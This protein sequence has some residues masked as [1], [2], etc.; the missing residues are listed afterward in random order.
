MR[1]ISLEINSFGPYAGHQVIDFRELKG[2]NLFL[3]CGP[4]GSGKTTVLDAMC[5]ALYGNTSGNDRTGATMRSEY[6]TPEQKT[7]VIFDFS[8]GSHLYRIERS[9][10]QEIAKKRGSGTKIETASAAFYEIDEEGNVL[11]PIAT[12]NVNG[13]VEKRLGFKSEQFRQVVLLPQGDF[14][15][16]LLAGSAERQEIM[17]VLFHTQRYGRFQELAKARY[18]AIEQRHAA[19]EERIVQVLQLAGAETEEGLDQRQAD[20]AKQLDQ[21]RA[22]GQRAKAERDA[23]QK[24]AAAAEVLAGHWQALKKG[25]QELLALQEQ[26][27][28]M[29]ERS[30][31]IERLKKAQ[32]LSEPCKYLDE[33]QDKGTAAGTALAEAQKKQEA[34][35]QDLVQARQR[36]ADV[37]SRQVTYKGE[38]EQLSRLKGLVEKVKAY[39][40][41][42][43]QFNTQQ[44]ACHK[45]AAAL[46]GVTARL[47]SAKEKI[48]AAQA[49]SEGLQQRRVAQEQLKNQQRLLHERVQQEERIAEL[50]KAI[51]AAHKD[52]AG[53]QAIYDE[54]AR[55]AHEAQV[56]YESVQALFLQGQAGLLAQTLQEGQVCPV[57]GSRQHPQLAVLADN[58]P[59]KEDVERCK[60]AADE[61]ADQSQRG[62]VAWEKVKTAVEAQEGQYKELRSQYAEDGSLASWQDR[63]AQGEALLKAQQRQLDELTRQVAEM[64]QLKEGLAQLERQVEQ[65]RSQADQARTAF[66]ATEAVL[67]Q[68]QAELPEQYR[69]E[70]ALQQAIGQVEKRIAAY[71]REVRDSRD[72]L[73][74]AEKAQA[75]WTEQ[76][77]I[78]QQQ[79]QELRQQYS[80]TMDAVKERVLAAGFST[81]MEC[82]TIQRQVPRLPEEERLRAAYDQQIQQVQGRIAQEEKTIAGVAE[83]DMAAYTA[84]LE[85]KNKKSDELARAAADL[86]NQQL[87]VTKAGQQIRTWRAEQGQLAEQY[88]TVGAVYELVSGKATGVNFERYVLGALLDD[89]LLAANLRLDEMSRHRYQLQRSNER[90]D[91]RVRRVGLDI[92]VFDSYTG[93]A[94]PANTLS[95]GETFLASLSLALGLADVVQAYSGGIHLDTIFIDEGFGTLDADTL[96][97]ALKALLDLEKGGRLVGII[98]HVPELRER[99]DTRLA[100]NKSDRGSTAAFEL[101]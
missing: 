50:K 65:A 1:P 83:P 7:S 23:Y 96:D 63:L 77:R 80:D 30:A 5:Y 52:E 91:R 46:E 17:Q 93:Y 25:Q 8:I 54:L 57:C 81:V 3:I 60:R 95:G 24:T 38:V 11:R 21:A 48:D 66:A 73:S 49:I 12:K 40:T 64:Q 36:Q 85:E 90:G 78:L 72:Q 15:K 22:E 16:L 14:R 67:S 32:L 53:K 62:R 101:L 37:E 98:S 13:E 61:R 26:E 31:F 59:Q 4:T 100:I 34:A 27:T 55:K 42:V 39:T 9:P 44:A 74:R 87:A 84:Q 45:T 18:D 99:I 76:V 68:A 2:R 41:V 35:E 51:D 70:T 29:R 97:F 33:I 82:R 43:G 75:R 92:E 58:M 28:A 69:V 79:V 6:A 94:R 71:D 20:L 47:Q 89:V 56:D 10:E 19:V 86:E 88:K